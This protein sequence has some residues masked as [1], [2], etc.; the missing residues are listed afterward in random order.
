MFTTNNFYYD[1]DSKIYNYDNSFTKDIIF[2][3]ELNNYNNCKLCLQ[4]KKRFLINKDS[5]NNAIYISTLQYNVS[6]DGIIIS[7]IDYKVLL[8]QAGY[9][10]YYLAY[11]NDKKIRLNCILYS[12]ML[13][14]NCHNDITKYNYIYKGIYIILN[15]YKKA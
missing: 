1:K 14:N 12:F 8:I 5:I 15:T 3:Y 7:F 10:L 4:K 2:H 6:E 11:T 13:D 9:N